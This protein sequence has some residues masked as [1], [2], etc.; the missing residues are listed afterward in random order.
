MEASDEIAGVEGADGHVGPSLK[1]IPQLQTIA[2]VLPNTTP[3]MVRWLL[4]PPRYVP[5]GDM[6]DLG[7]TRSE[8]KD[9]AAYLYTQ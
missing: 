7:V 6:P 9:I 2:G 5:T 4:D 1:Q 8:A 3:N